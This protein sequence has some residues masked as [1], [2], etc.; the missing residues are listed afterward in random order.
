LGDVAEEDSVKE[1]YDAV[2]VN[3]ASLDI[4]GEWNVGKIV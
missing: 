4:H 3:K 2:E 1:S